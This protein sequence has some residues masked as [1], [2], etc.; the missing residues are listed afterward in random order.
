M[1]IERIIN[2]LCSLNELIRNKYNLSLSREIQS[3][4]LDLSTLT[5]SLI[6]SL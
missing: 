3:I 2:F 4:S 1:N 5:A 6:F